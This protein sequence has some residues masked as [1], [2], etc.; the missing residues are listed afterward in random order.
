MAGDSASDAVVLRPAD[1]G[2]SGTVLHAVGS[3]PSARFSRS[4]VADSAVC[5]V[6]FAP[7]NAS[8]C[9]AATRLVGYLPVVEIR[10]AMDEQRVQPHVE[11][12]LDVFRKATHRR[13][14]F[15]HVFVANY[16]KDAND[17]LCRNRDR[18]AHG[19]CHIGDDVFL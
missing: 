11:I 13:R 15:S 6:S 2:A 10:V 8:K 7:A 18:R 12:A 17:E 5:R 1:V 16:P 14:Y 19:T 3:R 9:L 4:R